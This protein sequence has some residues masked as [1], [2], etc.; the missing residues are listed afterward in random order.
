MTEL[1][2][3]LNDKRVNSTRR[4]YNYK[5]IR[6]N[7]RTSKYMEQ[8]LI[9]KKGEVD[10]STVIVGYFNILLSIVDRTTRQI[11]KEIENLNYIINQSDLAD[12][13]RILDQ[14]HQNM[15]VYMCVVLSRSVMSDCL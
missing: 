1:I 9:E 5:H 7:S 15:Y 8:T 14:Q 12:S 4:Y 6:T 10:N 11:S 3:I 13:K 2:L